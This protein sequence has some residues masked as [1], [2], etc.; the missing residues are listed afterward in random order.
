M[1]LNVIKYPLIC[2]IH[3]EDKYITNLKKKQEN[4]L[5]RTVN[6]PLDM[7]ISIL[8]PISE[9]FGHFL[10]LANDSVCFK[11]SIIYL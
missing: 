4:F 10:N 8:D 11:Y 1:L 6:D 3:H 5:T 9:M 2:C 7:K